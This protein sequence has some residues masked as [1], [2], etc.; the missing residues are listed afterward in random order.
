MLTY[1]VIQDERLIF[2]E[3]IVYVIVGKNVHM[4]MC[5]ILDAYRNRAV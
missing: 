4:N 2:W 5:L 1:R 3:M